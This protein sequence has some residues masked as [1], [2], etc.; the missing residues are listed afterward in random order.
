M[1]KTL[2]IKCIHK[3]TN[4]KYI[5]KLLK[6]YP[7]VLGFKHGAQH[8]GKVCVCVEEDQAVL[9]RAPVKKNEGWF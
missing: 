5:H 6:S 3:I 8:I 1:L 7:N 9:F 2:A 4:K